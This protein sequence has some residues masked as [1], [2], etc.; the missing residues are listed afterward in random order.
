MFLLLYFWHCGDGRP[1][2]TSDHV[3]RTLQTVVIEGPSSAVDAILRNERHFW[4]QKVGISDYL[5]SINRL[6]PNGF[7]LQVGFTAHTEFKNTRYL[8]TIRTS[9]L[10]FKP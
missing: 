3:H 2:S 4:P 6:P 1:M 9:L 5:L 8:A 10:I 7:Q